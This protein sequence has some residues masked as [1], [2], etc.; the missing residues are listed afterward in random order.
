MPCWALD[1][2][3]RMGES[4]KNAVLGRTVSVHLYGSEGMEAV[5]ELIVIQLGSPSWPIEQIEGLSRVL[6]D[7]F[8][9]A[10]EEGEIRSI[11]Q[12]MADEFMS[13]QMKWNFQEILRENSVRDSIQYDDAMEVLRA[14]Y[15]AEPVMES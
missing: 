9:T 13:R 6:N 7:L 12:E 15:F 10:S 3:L 8:E 5:K 4:K 14:H 11:S 2:R 1:I